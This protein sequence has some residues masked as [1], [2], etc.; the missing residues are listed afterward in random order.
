[1]TWLWIYWTEAMQ[2]L[3]EQANIYCKVSG[4]VESVADKTQP[5]P[6]EVEFY[7]P[8]LNLLWNKFGQDRLIY[9]S[10][11]PVSARFAKYAT[12]QKLVLDYFEPK[13]KDATDKVFRQNS[14]VAYKW[15]DRVK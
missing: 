5:I 15:I 3:A 2:L 8:V 13:G 14:K 4:L 1:M 6:H 7:K 11:W 10:N 12:V 9:G